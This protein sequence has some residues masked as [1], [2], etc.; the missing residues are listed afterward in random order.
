MLN[1]IRFGASKGFL[2]DPPGLSLYMGGIKWL[3]VMGFG[4]G[5][6]PGQGGASGQ[7][8]RRV[9]GSGSGAPGEGRLVMGSG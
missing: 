6:A 1:L 2:Y 9:M 8:G 3:R 7:G 4:S 5:R